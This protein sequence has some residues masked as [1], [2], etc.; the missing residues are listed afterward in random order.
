MFLFSHT[1]SRPQFSSQ[2]LNVL[3]HE[4]ELSD[5]SILFICTF[6]C[7]IIGNVKAVAT[8]DTIPITTHV[9][10]HNFA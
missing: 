9:F 8:S 3:N 2:T 1:T 4:S 6:L 7:E 10:Y 5:T